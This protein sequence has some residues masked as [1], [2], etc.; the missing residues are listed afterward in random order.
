MVLWGTLHPNLI[1]VY[2]EPEAKCLR[3]MANFIPGS[4]G[5]RKKV[6][7]FSILGPTLASIS[8][9]IS[10]GMRMKFLKAVWSSLL[11]SISN[12]SY[13]PKALL[14]ATE[15]QGLV[16]YLRALLP[17]LLLWILMAASS[18]A[19]CRAKW[20]LS[21][22][23]LNSSLALL[24]SSIFKILVQDEEAARKVLYIYPLSAAPPPDQA[25]A[26]TRLWSK[27]TRYWAAEGPKQ[28]RPMSQIVVLIG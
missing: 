3:Q 9:N 27:W 2:L 13:M 14:L 5:S 6:C 8:S 12:W 15:S 7:C 19:S 24:A 26:M 4:I 11:S 1:L 22:A 23:L 16:Q 25:A 18:C 10:G 17:C 21:S 28:H 20:A